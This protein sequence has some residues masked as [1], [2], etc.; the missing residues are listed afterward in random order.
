MIEPGE[1]LDELLSSGDVPDLLESEMDQISNIMRN[2]VFIKA[3][4]IVVQRIHIERNL[5]LANTLQDQK[6]VVQCARSQ[7]VVGGVVHTIEALLQQQPNR[8][9]K[10]G[11]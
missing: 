3:L 6:D 7:G 10:D 5:M 2:P 1:Y 4:K 8:S 9:E 11:G